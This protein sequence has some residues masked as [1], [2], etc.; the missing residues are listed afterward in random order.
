MISNILVAIMVILALI[1]F[2][3]CFHTENGRNDTDEKEKR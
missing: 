1:A 3:W 2:V